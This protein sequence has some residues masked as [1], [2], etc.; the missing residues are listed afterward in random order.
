MEDI[1]EGVWC[2]SV[3][4]KKEWE[5]PQFQTDT[6]VANVFGKRAAFKQNER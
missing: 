4:G 3:F 5:D 2:E 1:P 6:H